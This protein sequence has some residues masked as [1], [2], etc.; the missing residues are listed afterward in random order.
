M[1]PC[2]TCGRIVGLFR[3]MISLLQRL[4]TTAGYPSAAAAEP[5]PHLSRMPSIVYGTAWKKERTAELVLAAVRAGFRAV[6]TACQPKHYHEA[7]VGD[8]LAQLASEGIGRDTLWIQTKF[9]PLAGQDPK[10]LPYEQFAPL[11]Q[12]V[13]ESVAASKRNLRVECVDCLLLHSP[14]PTH[15][16]TMRVWRAMEKAVVAGEA[17]TLGISNCYD[18][19]AFRRL[20][21]DAEV[22]PAVLQ[23]RFYQQSGYDVQLREMCKARGVRYQSFWTLTANPDH[24]QSETVAR[25]ATTHGCTPQQAWFAFTMALGITPLSGTTSA[26]HMRDDVSVAKTVHLEPDEV[27][28]LEKLI[29][30]KGSGWFG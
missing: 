24:I 28:E 20:C 18:A 7:G 9:T 3:E 25:V 13:A 2:R 6:D 8:A 12:Q 30:P 1:H 17:C 4:F 22:K 11:E 16:D 5:N 29:R 21:E 19:T 27:Q 23:N 15:R 26:E 10:Q 14:L